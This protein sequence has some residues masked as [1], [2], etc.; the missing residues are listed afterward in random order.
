[1]HR[2][3]SR[4]VSPFC[5][6]HRCDR[7]SS[8]LDELVLTSIQVSCDLSKYQSKPE[9]PVPVCSGN[10]CNTGYRHSP[11]LPVCCSVTLQAY[12]ERSSQG[13]GYPSMFSVRPSFCS[14]NLWKVLENRRD[15]WKVEDSQCY[16]SFQKGQEGEARELQASQHHL[17][18]W[19]CDGTVILETIS[20]HMKKVVLRGSQCGFTKWKSGQSILVTSVV[21]QLA[22]RWGK[23]CEYPL[24]WLQQGFWCHLLWDLCREADALW[25]GW[26]DDELDSKLAEWPDPESGIQWHKVWLETG[27]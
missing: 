6:G 18:L 24:P 17:N 27:Y 8:L 23:R 7:P 11:S 14:C 2:K 10:V 1:M 15:A 3:E 12:A 25:S 4:D 20:S 26:A 5:M 22:C 21:K 13:M 9:C 16:T 19:E